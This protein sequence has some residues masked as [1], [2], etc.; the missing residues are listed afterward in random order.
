MEFIVI[1]GG[2]NRESP[3]RTFQTKKKVMFFVT[4]VIYTTFSLK[5]E[6]GLVCPYYIKTAF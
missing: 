5:N 6:I 3:R 1:L 4:V 2:K